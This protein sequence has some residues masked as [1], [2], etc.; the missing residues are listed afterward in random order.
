MLLAAG[1]A[2]AGCAASSA[3]VEAAPAPEGEHVAEAEQEPEV[4]CKWE[5]AVGSRIKKKVCRTRATIEA[6]KR[7]AH[8][9][10]RRAQ[11]VGSM[12][13]TDNE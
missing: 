7:N 12:S 13:T 4:V 1:L 5:A 2:L 3:T 8:R 11:Q 6:E 9:M 10:M